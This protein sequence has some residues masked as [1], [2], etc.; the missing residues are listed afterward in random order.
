[1]FANLAINRDTDNLNIYL[2]YDCLLKNEPIV[3]KGIKILHNHKGLRLHARPKR[4]A[5]MLANK[6]IISQQNS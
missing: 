3:N 6:R 5:S 4:V 2:I 1:M